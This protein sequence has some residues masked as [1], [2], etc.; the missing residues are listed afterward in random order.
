[1]T[2]TSDELTAQIMTVSDHL[3]NWKSAGNIADII[4]IRR[5]SQDIIDTCMDIELQAEQQNTHS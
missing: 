2:F 4:E 5:I 1:M 3:A